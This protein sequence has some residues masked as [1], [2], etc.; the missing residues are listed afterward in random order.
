MFIVSLIGISLTRGE[1]LYCFFLLA[2]VNLNPTLKGIAL[3]VK[4]GIIIINN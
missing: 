2:I 3:S 4:Y 1:I